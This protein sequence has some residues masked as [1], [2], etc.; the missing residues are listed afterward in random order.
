MDF[1]ENNYVVGIIIIGLV[2]YSACLKP[3]LPNFIKK[4]FN[5]PI[6]RLIIL[7]LILVSNFKPQISIILAIAFFITV[8][9]ITEQ[10]TLETFAQ[11]NVCITLN[12]QKNCQNIDDSKL[13]FGVL[14]ESVKD[15]IILPNIQST[16]I[17]M[18]GMQSTGTQMAGIQSTGT[19]MMDIQST[20]NPSISTQ[21][22]T[23][24]STG[25]QLTTNPSIST[26][27]TTNPSTGTQ[28]TTNSTTGTQ[29]M[30]SV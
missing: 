24:T 6:V 8:N 29:Q 14:F 21:L 22:T 12:G 13:N 9:C 11:T 20:T 5:N 26:Q 10:E 15:G 1:L 7:A 19:Q 30:T 17:Q 3:N 28:L 4:I 25:T 2:V 23:N 18:A 27:L 16:G